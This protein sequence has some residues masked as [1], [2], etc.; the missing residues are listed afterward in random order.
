MWRYAAI[1]ILPG[2]PR[3]PVQGPLMRKIAV[4]TAVTMV[5]AAGQLDAQTALRPQPS[6]RAT[7]E[8]VLEYPEGQAPAGATGASIKI[9]YGVPHLR[10]RALQR[11][12]QVIDLHALAEIGIDEAGLHQ[13]VA[14]DHESRRDRQH[15][16]VI[17]L[18]TRHVLV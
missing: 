10:G 18:E 8:V 1:C 17:A 11:G 5:L 7:S 4:Y 6:G 2:P 14:P 15:P 13:S 3:F 9:D 16:A 12:D